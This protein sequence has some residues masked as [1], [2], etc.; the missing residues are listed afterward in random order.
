[1]L[2]HGR[3][4]PDR[5][6]G[7]ETDVTIT[8]VCKLRYSSADRRSHDTVVRFLF[9]TDGYGSSFV[10]RDVDGVWRSA[11]PSAADIAADDWQPNGE[12]GR[13]AEVPT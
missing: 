2:L 11:P 8:E 9:G 1:M 3:H 6:L 5:L 10:F 12:P 7:S 13:V 4:H